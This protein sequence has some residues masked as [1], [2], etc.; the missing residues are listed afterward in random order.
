MRA[1][2]SSNDQQDQRY[3]HC[4][5]RVDAARRTNGAT[6]NQYRSSGSEF[7]KVPLIKVAT[8]GGPE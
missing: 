3:E 6:C 1:V 4:E 8:A 2:G 5:V 7:E